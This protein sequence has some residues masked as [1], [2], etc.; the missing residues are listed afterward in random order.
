MKIDLKRYNCDKLEISAEIEIPPELRKN[1]RDVARQGGQ[2]EDRDTIF[3]HHDYRRSKSKHHLYILM[4]QLAETE[5]RALVEINYRVVD[6]GRINKTR[7]LPEYLISKITT[8]ERIPFDCKCGFELRREIITAPLSSMPLRLSSDEGA[9]EVLYK[10]VYVTLLESGKPTYDLLFQ[11]LDATEGPV[12]RFIFEFIHED[13][14]SFQLP[15]NVLNKALSYVSQF[16]G[17]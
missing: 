15:Q 12:F 3:F 13:Q 8:K 11:V 17:G 7:Y 2:L 9:V 6:P 1:L 4:E 10:G 14:L 5:Q 16:V